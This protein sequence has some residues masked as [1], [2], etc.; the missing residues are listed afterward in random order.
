VLPIAPL[1]VDVPWALSD[2]TS[3]RRPEEPEPAP[4]RWWQL[5]RSKPLSRHGEQPPLLA[6]A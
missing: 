5:W 4:K 1:K 2:G 3:T 6:P